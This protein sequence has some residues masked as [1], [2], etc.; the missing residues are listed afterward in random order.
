MRFFSKRSHVDEV[1]PVR[2]SP[3]ELFVETDGVQAISVPHATASIQRDGDLPWIVRDELRRWIAS[4]P[5]AWPALELVAAE[6]VL[7]I[8]S[9]R[10]PVSEPFGILERSRAVIEGSGEREQLETAADAF[11]GVLDDVIF[12]A[13]GDVRELVAPMPASRRGLRLPP[14]CGRTSEPSRRSSNRARTNGRLRFADRLRR[15]AV[16]HGRVPWAMRNVGACTGLG[17]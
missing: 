17:G 9:A 14:C 6:H 7:P 10:H 12:Q 13:N 2:L 11:R 4:R 1:A 15:P 16:Q 5:G 8:W 3:A